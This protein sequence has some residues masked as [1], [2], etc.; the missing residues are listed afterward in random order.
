MVIEPQFNWTDPFGPERGEGTDTG[1]AVLQPR[2]SVA[3]H[4]SLELFTPC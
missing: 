1:M 2:Q 3:Y 4:A